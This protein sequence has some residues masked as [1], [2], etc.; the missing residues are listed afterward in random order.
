MPNRF[1]EISF[2]SPIA[3]IEP[4]LY[5]GIILLLLKRLPLWHITNANVE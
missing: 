5:F 3:M 2:V 1:S 4:F